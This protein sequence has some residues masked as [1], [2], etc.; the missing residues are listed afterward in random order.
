MLEVQLGGTS[1]HCTATLNALLASQ[2][3][4][5]LTFW[6]LP[7]LPIFPVPSI[8]FGHKLPI[9]NPS[10]SVLMPSTSWNIT[11]FLCPL[12]LPILFFSLVCVTLSEF[13]HCTLCCVCIYT[14]LVLLP[15]QSP[16]SFRLLGSH[17]DDCSTFS[18]IT[19][20]LQIFFTLG[21]VCISVH[22]FFASLSSV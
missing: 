21:V 4:V 16:H 20:L 14:A 9:Q 6:A 11:A 17:A 19:S 1:L 15:S 3:R 22:L 12:N 7:S 13:L 2:T 10:F 5:L 18:S 8:P